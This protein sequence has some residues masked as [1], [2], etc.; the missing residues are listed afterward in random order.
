MICPVITVY[1]RNWYSL[2]SRLFVGGSELKSCEGTTQRDTAA[3]TIYAI[4]TIPLL[5][6][7]V[8][9]A[10]QLA[11]KRS[12][13]VAYPDEFTGAGWITN[14]LHWWNTLTTLGPLFGYHIGYVR[15]KIIEQEFVQYSRPPSLNFVETQ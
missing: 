8:D 10:E 15:N 3:M 9:Q 13:W 6:M 4:A 11:E 14:L 12:K 2:P 7:L 5:P 1:V